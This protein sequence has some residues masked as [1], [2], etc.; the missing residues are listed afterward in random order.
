LKGQARLAT[1]PR[2]GEGKEPGSFKQ[3]LNLGD[4]AFAPDKAGELDR[5]VVE[6]VR[7]RRDRAAPAPSRPRW[8]SPYRSLCNPHPGPTWHTSASTI[9][10]CRHRLT[11]EIRRAGEVDLRELRPTLY[12]FDGL[13]ICALGTYS[14]NM[15][16]QA[17]S[18][19]PTP[20]P[21]HKPRPGAGSSSHRT[22]VPQ[23]AG[24]GEARYR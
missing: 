5:E 20:W 2:S 1:T 8:P 16:T 10:E 4:L 19:F 17:A 15:V 11:A 18:V 24:L 12:G 6:T 3:G 13:G 23:A 7:G 21:P 22:D 9:R 14:D